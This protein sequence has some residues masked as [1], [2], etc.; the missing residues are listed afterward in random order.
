MFVVIVRRRDHQFQC[1]R[2]KMA[3]ENLN[4]V[5]LRHIRAIGTLIE[6]LQ[7]ILWQWDSHTI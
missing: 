7:N 2:E 5:G 4:F 1:M 3:T 6:V